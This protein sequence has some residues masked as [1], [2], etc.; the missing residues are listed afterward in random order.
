MC[1]HAQIFFNAKNMTLSVRPA[2]QTV[3]RVRCCASRAVQQGLYCADIS[4]VLRRSL[5][6]WVRWPQ[7]RSVTDGTSTAL[8]VCC[9]VKP[10]CVCIT[11]SIERLQVTSAAIH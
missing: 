1:D 6:T 8:P 7:Q 5:T 2:C 10:C 3:T 9:I 4:T 11:V